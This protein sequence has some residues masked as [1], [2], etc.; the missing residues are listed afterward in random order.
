MESDNT[1]IVVVGMERSAKY[2]NC[3]G[4][5]HDAS[6]MCGIL[7]KYG[8][9]VVLRDSAAKRSAVRSALESALDS[10]LLI[11]YYSGHGGSQRAHPGSG[12]EDGMDEYLCLYDGPMMDDEVWSILKNAK[13][14]AFCIFDC[15]HSA[16]MY[17]MVEGEPVSAPTSSFTM[18]LASGPLEQ[19]NV[20]LLVWSGCPDSDFSYGDAEGGVLTNAIVEAFSANRSYDDVWTRVKRR[21]SGQTPVKT[22]L[23]IGFGGK[24]FR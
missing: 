6:A 22:Q 13:G 21:V 8:T 4:S 18:Q 20:N 16:T 2:G 19:G 23:G 17:Q 10:E 9:P 5:S 3:P 14:R 1:K 24:V 12:E 11:F 15:C 7:S